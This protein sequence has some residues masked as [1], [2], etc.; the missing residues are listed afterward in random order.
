MIALFVG[1]NS[2]VICRFSEL[3]Y[4]VDVQKS[5]VISAKMADLEVGPLYSWSLNILGRP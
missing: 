1:Y 2:V 4:S 5:T 3:C